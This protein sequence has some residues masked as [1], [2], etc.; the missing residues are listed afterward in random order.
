MKC[1]NCGEEGHA[2]RDCTQARVGG[3][4][5]ADKKCYVSSCLREYEMCAD[6]VEMIEL[7]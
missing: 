6:G 3:A 7:R 1:Y 4:F 2:S 5:G